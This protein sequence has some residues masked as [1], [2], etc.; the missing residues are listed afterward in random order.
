MACVTSRRSL[1][2]PP[3]FRSAG[4]SWSALL[5]RVLALDVLEC[6]RSAAAGA[7]SS[8]CTPV[9]RAF[10]RCS[11][12]WG[13]PIPPRRRPPHARL[14]RLRPARHN[15]P[16]FRTPSPR[17]P[18]A[19]RSA[20]PTSFASH[21]SRTAFPAPGERFSAAL[22]LLSLPDCPRRGQNRLTAPL[23]RAIL[24][25]ARE[26]KQ[27]RPVVSAEAKALLDRLWERCVQT[28][29]NIRRRGSPAEQD[30]VLFE[31]L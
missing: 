9:G 15:A 28:R 12:G 19:T 4:L 5:K 31:A 2:S 20:L 8:P 10:G 18:R 7:A 21:R 26:D 17:I 22:R 23:R 14:R 29:E 30:L 3:P 1:G 16:V 27:K 11:S 6:P 24:A 13:L 25:R